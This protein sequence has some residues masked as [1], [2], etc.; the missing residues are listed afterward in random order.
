[1]ENISV[2]VLKFP[3]ESFLSEKL[4]EKLNNI[5]RLNVSEIIYFD[6]ISSLINKVSTLNNDCLIIVEDINKY[7]LKKELNDN[8]E[9]KD[10]VNIKNEYKIFVNDYIYPKYDFTFKLYGTSPV[11]LKNYFIVNEFNYE[12]YENSGDITVKLDSDS[13]NFTETIKDFIVKYKRFI[14]AEKDVS[15]AKMAIDIM[16]L[17]KMKLSV[18]ES[19]TGGMVSKE[20]TS[21]SGASNVFYEGLVTYNENSKIDRLGVNDE[22]IKIDRPVSA[23]T[24]YEMCAGLL[25]TGNVDYAISTTGIAGPKSDSS[26]FPVGLCF[27]AVGS[28]DKIRVFKFNFQGNRHNIISQGKNMA[29]FLLV[30]LLRNE[31]N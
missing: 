16:T 1:M 5:N 29:I 28:A 10:G 26:N 31:L 13:I 2:L 15:L 6:K 9:E 8:F 20:F 17:R 4:L 12:L 19:F 27:I 25:N 14:Y 22:T 30:K 11:E 21:I 18:A 7:N 3:Y 24:A 23:K